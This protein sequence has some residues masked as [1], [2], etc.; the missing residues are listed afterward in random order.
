MQ[1]NGMECMYVCMNVCMHA[2]MY[3]CM[4]VSLPMC[5]PGNLYHGQIKVG[6]KISPGFD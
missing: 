4:C 2:C 1:W 6:S 3:V 5:K